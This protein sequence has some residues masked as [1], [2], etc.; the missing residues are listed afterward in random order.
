MML[1]EIIKIEKGSKPLEVSLSPKPGYRRLLQIED[2]RA[3]STPK[4]CPPAK[5]E[6][7]A[8]STDVIIAWDGANA[9]T[10]SFGLEG[11]IGSTLALLRPNITDL[12]TP[13][14]GEYIRA[15]AA[16]LRSKCKGATVPHLDGAILRGLDVPLLSV[17]EQKRIALL[18]DKADSIR[19]RRRE[20]FSLTDEFLRS[21]FL[22]MFGDATAW[23][24]KT[25]ET[26]LADKPNAIRTGP[27]GSQ[28]LHGEFVDSGIAVLGID[29]AVRN[30]FSW[31]KPR[32]IT[33][34]KYAQ[35]QRYTVYPGDLI[36]TIMGTVGRCA[37]V[38]EDIPLAINTKH[39]CCLTLDNSKCLPEFLHA[40]LLYHPIAARHLKQACKGA[41]MDGLNMGVIKSLPVPA[42]P[43]TLQERFKAIASRVRHTKD[44]IATHGHEADN[45]FQS[46]QQRAFAGAL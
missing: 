1:G 16:F 9:G 31:G 38:P 2:L 27:F 36:I 10:S 40:Y 8:R 22:E 7:M 21:L 20:A 46:L 30:E 32:F 13:Y 34:K 26:M 24:M 17:S 5:D 45:L 42:V 12:H 37:V 25:V 44:R 19:R 11:V 15:N 35:L 43:M 29:N 6:V 14:L 41:I 3:N 33:P 4:Y 18:L 28:L 39:L 23:V